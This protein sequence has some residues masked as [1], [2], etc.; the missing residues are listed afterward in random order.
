MDFLNPKLSFDENKP[1]YPLVVNCLTQIHGFLE[2]V[3]RGVKTKMEGFD[4]GELETYINSLA[5][6]DK[7]AWESVFRG[8][9]TGLFGKME[10]ESKATGQGIQIDNDLLA[11]ELF[12]KNEGPVTYVN[13]MSAGSLLILA[14]EITEPHHTKDPLWQFLR[15]CRNAA[16]HNGHFTFYPS[17][18]NSSGNL[19]YPAKWRGF[20]I[21]SSLQGQPLFFSP[22]TPG[23][24]GAGDPF[25][26][27][28]DIEQA[29][30][31]IK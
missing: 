30:P 17:V 6:N 4:A 13:R 20:E 16:A 23:F 19:K 21:L 3:S 29:Y 24:L 15:H 28:W 8:G 18:L 22:P 12:D 25:Y 11:K 26:L 1:F 31:N 10:L 9:K 5:R 7:D 14:W 2:L 27:L